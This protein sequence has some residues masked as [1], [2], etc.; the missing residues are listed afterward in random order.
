M[1]VSILSPIDYALD[2]P[3]G[4]VIKKA[5]VRGGRIWGILS[6]QTIIDKNRILFFADLHIKPQPYVKVLNDIDSILYIYVS[7]DGE[8]CLVRKPDQIFY[9]S[10]FDFEPCKI[11]LP[12]TKVCAATFFKDDIYPKPLI[13]LVT[14]QYQVGLVNLNNKYTKFKFDIIP[15]SIDQTKSIKDISIVKFKDGFY[16]FSVIYQD[17]IIPYILDQYFAQ[18]ENSNSSYCSQIGLINNYFTGNNSIGWI[19]Q[20]SNNKDQMAFEYVYDFKDKHPNAA[21]IFSRQYAYTL[22][23]GRTIGTSFFEEFFLYFQE[24]GR[25]NIFLTDSPE[26]IDGFVV[27]DANLFEYDA[28]EGELYA[29]YPNRVSNIKFESS[30]KNSFRG[31]DSLRYWLFNRSLARKDEK[32]AGR[33]IINMKSISMNEIFQKVRQPTTLRYYVYK[34]ILKILRKRKPTQK[35]PQITKQKVAIA[36]ATYDIYTRIEMAKKKPDLKKYCE[37]TKSLLNEGLLNMSTVKK[38][39]DEYGWDSPYIY[40]SEPLLVFDRLMER[41]EKKKALQILPQISTKDEKFSN[42]LLRVFPFSK[43]TVVKTV[44]KLD[45]FDNSN[46]VP[47]LMDDSSRN[48]VTSFVSKGCHLNSWA[49]KLCAIVSAR[50]EKLKRKDVDQMFTKFQ[51]SNDGIIQFIA[52]EFISLKKFT[53]LSYGFISIREF[54]AAS[55]AAARSKEVLKLIDAIFPV[56]KKNQQQPQRQQSK[57]NLSQASIDLSQQ[58]EYEMDNETKKR[59]IYTIL[60]SVEPEKAGELAKNLIYRLSYDSENENQLDNNE[61]NE[62]IDSRKGIDSTILMLMEFLPY[63]TKIGDLTL[64]ITEFTKQKRKETEEQDKNINKALAGIVKI[65]SQLKEQKNSENTIVLHS[66]EICEKCKKPFFKEPGIVFPCSHMLHVRCARQLIMGIED[67]KNESDQKYD[68]GRIDITNKATSTSEIFQMVAKKVR[69]SI[70]AKKNSN[71]NIESK[72]TVMNENDDSL[73][74]NVDFCTDCPLC[75]YLSVKLMNEP[76]RGIQVKSN[77]IDPFTTDISQL[78]AIVNGGKKTSFFNI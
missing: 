56:H 34:H 26:L 45:S 6:S 18:D 25:V 20:C 3:Q 76:F 59:C 36:Y 41:N 70:P 4:F 31:V 46:F 15:L 17:A 57:L 68:T 21:K 52:R 38:T 44:S 2:L 37:F 24:G 69:I 23:N 19:S 51:F 42:A 32:T 48:L 33:L 7:N 10:A 13:F 62:T 53:E 16:G 74:K 11:I 63:D 50:D 54:V 30:P 12:D 49:S 35:D 28:D 47:I 72:D 5:Y 9:L 22:P 55:A 67:N 40:L 1:E 77:D 58:E 65:S 66:T 14:D 27:K 61:N 43:E 71:I 29:I 64:P 75:G 60:R 8:F 78:A 39:L 73:K